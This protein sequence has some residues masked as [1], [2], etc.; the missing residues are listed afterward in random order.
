MDLRSQLGHL[1]SKVV[2][3]VVKANQ[4]IMTLYMWAKLTDSIPRSNF[5]SSFCETDMAVEFDGP[6]FAPCPGQKLVLYNSGDN[7]VAGSIISSEA[8]A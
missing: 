3:N 5:L 4:I 1:E 8:T 7:I 6:Q 2:F